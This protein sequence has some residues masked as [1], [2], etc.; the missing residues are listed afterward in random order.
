MF[1]EHQVEIIVYAN[2]GTKNIFVNVMSGRNHCLSAKKTIK[3]QYFNNKAYSPTRSLLLV[4]HH[5]DESFSC[6]SITLDNKWS[7]G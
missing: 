1:N 5:N 7:V 3:Q 6:T 2:V 4:M